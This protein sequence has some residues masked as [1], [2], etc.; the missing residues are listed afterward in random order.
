MNHEILFRLARAFANKTDGSEQ[1]RA[2]LL[3]FSWDGSSSTEYNQHQLYGWLTTGAYQVMA[4]RVDAELLAH[5]LDQ[6]RN[7]PLVSSAE[8]FSSDYAVF[9][10]IERFV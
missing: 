10:E 9:P 2:Q 6:A 1:I 8:P 4:K 7:V 3:R 5:F